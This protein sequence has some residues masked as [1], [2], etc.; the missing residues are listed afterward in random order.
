MFSLSLDIDIQMRPWSE[1]IIGF[2]CIQPVSSTK[3]YIALFSRIWSSFALLRPDLDS[4]VYMYCSGYDSIIGSIKSCA[5][6]KFKRCWFGSAPCC[7][8]GYL[9]NIGSRAQFLSPIS[10]YRCL[11]S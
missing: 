10:M 9:C 6:M 11:G 5:L 4:L 3:S 7:R 1:C 8:G 2:V